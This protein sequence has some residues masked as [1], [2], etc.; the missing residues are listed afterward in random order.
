AGVEVNERGHVKH[1]DTRTTAA[2]IY[3]VGDITYDIALANVGEIEGRHAVERIY[4]G[5]PP[6][7]GYENMSTIIFADPEIA[8]I[9]LNELQAQKKRIPYRVAVYSYPLV[10]RAIAMRSTEG[11]VKLLVTDDDEMKILGMRCLGVHASTTLEAVSL[12]INQGRS[13]RDL[14]ELIH[15]HPAITEGLQECVRMLMGISIYK[16]DVFTSDLRLSRMAYE[17]AE[18]ETD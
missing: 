4:G 13:A 16:P 3:A 1:N 7:F 8:A 5:A 12:M 11:F 2:H 14:A 18:S 6:A 9:G 15:P 10:N 17:P